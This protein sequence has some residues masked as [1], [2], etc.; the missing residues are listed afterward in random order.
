MGQ[1]ISINRI[2]YENIQKFIKNKDNNNL[3]LI[4]TLET[5]NQE[6][7]IY[8]TVNV[9]DEIN[10]INDYLKKNNKTINIIIY[11][12]NSSDDS[13]VKKYN[14]LYKL[15]FKNVYIYIGGLFEWL[16]L[17][18][19]Y[20]EEEFPTTNKILDILQYKGKIINI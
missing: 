5:T 20:G 18:D 16:L 8:K 3:I 15:G 2:N 12:M 14:Q 6:C 4:N 17:Q 1:N 19:I 9:N 7:L 13:V 10:I 11:G